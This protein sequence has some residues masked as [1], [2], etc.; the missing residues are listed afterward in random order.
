MRIAVIGP[1]NTG[2]TTFIKDFVQNFP[3]Y[4]TPEITYRD[5]VAKQNL[6]INQGANE[7]SQMVITNFLFDQITNNKE[8]NIIFDR[9]VIDNYVYA[10]YLHELGRFGPEIIQ[11]IK[12]MALEHLPNLDVLILIPTALGVV[13]VDDKTR[14]TDNAFIDA[15]NRLFIDILLEISQKSEVKIITVTGNREKRIELVKKALK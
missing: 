5:V 15:V 2:K 6:A 3:E 12:S 8:Q 9:C 1:Q 14:D 13:L 4:I 7:E 11:K 10:S